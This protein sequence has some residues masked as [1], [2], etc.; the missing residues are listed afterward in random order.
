MNHEFWE[1]EQLVIL[2]VA[3]SYYVDACHRGHDIDLKVIR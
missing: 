2:T 3:G 1:C